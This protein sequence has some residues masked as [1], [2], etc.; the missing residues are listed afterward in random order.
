MDRALSADRVHG[1]RARQA[2]GAGICSRVP[3]DAVATVTVLTFGGYLEGDGGLVVGRI[4]KGVELDTLLDRLGLH[5]LVI[6]IGFKNGI[7]RFLGSFQNRHPLR[8]SVGNLVLCRGVRFGRLLFDP[9]RGFLGCLL[10]RMT[11]SGLQ[12]AAGEGR[13]PQ[14]ADNQ[15]Q[16]PQPNGSNCEAI[17]YTV[18]GAAAEGDEGIDESEGERNDYPCDG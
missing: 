8:K 4:W 17:G 18:V 5:L 15:T 7:D 6:F 13:D 10:V 9:L 12:F 16:Q 11:D 3:T 1:N 14:P 2:D